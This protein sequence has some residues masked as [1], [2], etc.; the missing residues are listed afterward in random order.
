MNCYLISWNQISFTFFTIF[1]LLFRAPQ[2]FEAH[3]R[4]LCRILLCAKE[5][6]CLGK[7]EAKKFMQIENFFSFRT[8][9][10]HDTKSLLCWIHKNPPTSDNKMMSRCVCMHVRRKVSPS[11]LFYFESQLNFGETSGK[12]IRRCE[13]RRKNWLRSRCNIASIIS[14]CDN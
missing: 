1:F 2:A 8:S 12:R 14:I 10:K 5:R 6:R 13:M 3:Q 4:I 11:K 7:K 9:G